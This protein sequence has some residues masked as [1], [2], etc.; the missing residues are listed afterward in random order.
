LV[1]G[2]SGVVGSATQAALKRHS[3]VIAVRGRRDADFESFDQTRALFR[4]V[5]PTLVVHLAGAVFG[6]GG[7][8]AFPGDAIRRNILINTHVVAAAA[9]FGAKKIVAMGTTAIYSDE[10][11]QP[12]RESDALRGAPHG[13]ELSY[14]YAKRAML[15]QLEAYER[16][17]GLKF[18]YAIATNMFGPH[19]RFDPEYGHVVPSL[20]AKFAAASKTPGTQVQVWGDGSPT[21]D[22]LYA[23]DAAEGLALLLEK[24]EGA[25]NLATGVSTSIRAMVEEIAACFPQTPY[26]WDVTKPKGQLRRAYDVRRLQALGFAPKHS[27]RE[28]VQATVAWYLTHEGEARRT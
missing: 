1:T 9:E 27:L 20:I 12:F 10:A 17:F 7:N 15:V 19:D 14:A 22:F 4:F 8:M 6:V 16:Q 18:A 28:A 26:V 21:R 25:Y 13:S 3:D 5:K 24:G 23:A 11:E 2:A